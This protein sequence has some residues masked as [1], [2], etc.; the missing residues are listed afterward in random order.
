M[1][2]NL[3]PIAAK[4]PA[5]LLFAKVPR[6]GQ[7]KTR[8]AGKIGPDAAALLH[9][10]FVAD[11]LHLLRELPFTPYLFLAG[12][13]QGANHFARRLTLPR[14]VRVEMQHGRDLGERLTRAFRKL[15]KR[16]P[17]LVILGSDSPT[18]PGAY[19]RQA[20]RE[21]QVCDAVLGPCP[22]GGYYLIGLRR[23][24]PTRLPPG[25]LGDIRWG[26]RHAFRDTQ[27]NFLREGLPCS[28]LEEW[29][30]VD[31]GEDLLRLTR[32]LK[33][34]PALRRRAARTYR[35]LKKLGLR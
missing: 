16:Y 32:N 15:L 2:S 10:A 22:D 13:S 5:L 19:V 31:T 8:L 12:S 24:S 27:R 18:L 7:V 29:P 1:A 35:M 3:T 20:F 26:T 21:L 28:I 4:K 30:D 23:F 6:P 9:I 17:A 25:L 33:R 14:R 11:T 34:S